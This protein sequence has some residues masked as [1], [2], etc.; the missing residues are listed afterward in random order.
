M[1]LATVA[2]ATFPISKLA[3]QIFSA[4]DPKSHELPEDTNM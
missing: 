2:L 4:G 3:R 1:G